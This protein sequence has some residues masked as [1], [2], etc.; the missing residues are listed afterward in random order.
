MQQVWRIY[1]NEI[2]AALILFAIIASGL[3]FVIAKRHPRTRWEKYLRS[4]GYIVLVIGFVV[5][6]YIT[7]RKPLSISGRSMDFDVLGTFSDVTHGY[8][9]IGQVLGNLL[10]L[11]WLGWALA[12]LG[13][14]LH[15]ALMVGMAVSVL[16]ELIQFAMGD[17]RVASLADV[18][19]NVV[20][21]APAWMLG[22]ALKPTTQRQVDISDDSSGIIG[23]TS[24]ENVRTP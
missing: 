23:Q 6:S 21:I 24:G 2:I 8:T 20:G 3:W 22:S 15:R 5:T 4:L 19:F 17:G 7:L 10:L 16:I 1:G 12:A 11:S 18:L 14:R 9:P 13:V